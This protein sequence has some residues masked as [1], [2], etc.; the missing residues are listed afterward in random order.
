MDNPHMLRVIADVAG[1]QRNGGGWFRAAGGK[2]VCQGWR[3]F[4]AMARR[5]GWLVAG[6]GTQISARVYVPGVVIDWRAVHRDL[7]Q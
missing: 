2:S 3:E 4:G 6:R 7:Q 1:V 5:R